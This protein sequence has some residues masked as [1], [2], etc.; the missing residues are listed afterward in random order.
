[1]T[2]YEALRNG[3]GL[4]DLSGRGE[5]IA[6][7]RDR[8]RLLH[9]VSSNEVKKMTPGQ[10]C[11]AFLLTTQGRI[12]ADLNLF[13]FDDHFLID[14]EPELREKVLAHVRKYIIADQ[15]DLEDASTTIAAIGLE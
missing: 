7:G 3:A 5:I 15:V 14:T 8:A 9:N 11:Y 10:G 2:G 1:M 12:Q 4:L 6:R 13:C